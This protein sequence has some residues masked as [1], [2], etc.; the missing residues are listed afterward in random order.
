MNGTNMEQIVNCIREQI[1]SVTGMNP[2][3]LDE[4]MSFIKC[5][6]SS[7]Q[8]I[9]ILN[10]IKKKLQADINPVAMFEYKNISELSSYLY[11]CKTENAL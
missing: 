7:L 5:G 4:R 11:R 10:R 8:A 3:D 6:I 9:M 1:A 2:D